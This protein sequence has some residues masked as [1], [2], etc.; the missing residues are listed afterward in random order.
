MD[1]LDISTVVNIEKNMDALTITSV[2]LVST[3]LTKNTSGN[4]NQEPLSTVLRLSKNYGP[5]EYHLSEMSHSNLLPMSLVTLPK[6]LMDPN[7]TNIILDDFL[8][9]QICPRSL[10]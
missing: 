4:P 7:L 6:K 2:Y 9:T 10:Q 5:S 3:F 8:N 1:T